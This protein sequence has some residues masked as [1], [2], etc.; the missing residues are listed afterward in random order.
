MRTITSRHDI[1]DQL[2]SLSWLRSSWIRLVST[3]DRNG[4][5]TSAIR[6][7][8]GRIWHRCH[9]EYASLL[10]ATLNSVRPIKLE[11]LTWLRP[12]LLRTKT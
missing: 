4:C 10:L 12:Y 6:T 3:V 1:R 8:F 5:F 9:F 2:A 11:D 7:T